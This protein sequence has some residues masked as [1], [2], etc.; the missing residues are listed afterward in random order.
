MNKQEAI[1]GIKSEKYNGVL[2]YEEEAYNNGLKDAI[3]Y[4][5][6]INMPERPVLTK[7]EAE[8]IDGLKEEQKRRPFWTKY[9]MLYFVTRA[10]FGYGFSYDHYRDDREVELEHYSH[11]IHAEKERLTNAI[12]YGYEVE[13]KKLY[14]VELPNPNGDGNRYGLCKAYGRVVIRSFVFGLDEAIN[15]KLTEEE[16]KE[17]FDWAWQFAKEVEE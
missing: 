11:E 6:K 1:K 4:V 2:T 7:E 3:G 15:T 17:D 14:T 12:L 9:S 16:I 13:K 5:E 8:W 10:G